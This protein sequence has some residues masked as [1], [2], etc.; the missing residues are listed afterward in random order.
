MTPA[1][2]EYRELLSQ[3]EELEKMATQDYGGATYWQNCEESTREAVANANWRPDEGRINMIHP[4]PKETCEAIHG[5]FNMRFM[6]QL[7]AAAAVL[8]REEAKGLKDRLKKERDDLEK[9][10]EALK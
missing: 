10:L 8:L 1:L 6:E 7:W 2:K 5:A 9:E 4:L 3:A